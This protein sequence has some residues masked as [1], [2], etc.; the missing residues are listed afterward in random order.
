MKTLIYAHRGASGYAPENTNEAFALAMEQGAEGVELD[1][2]LT[3]DG[4]VIVTH[5]ERIDRVSDGTGL[6]SMLSV[7]D[8][9]K[10]LFNRTHPEYAEARAPLLEEVLE[11]MKPSGMG[12]NIELKNSRIPY[13][14]MESKC[15]DLAAKMGME[16]RI[17]YSSFNHHSMTFLKSLNPDAVCG[18]L[19]DCSLLKP[20]DYLKL[21]GVN[22]LHP[23]YS[24]LLLN[25][26]EY[27]RVQEQGGLIHVWT[28]NDDRAMRKVMN[29]GADILIT[30]FPDRAL[31]VRDEAPV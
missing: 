27:E 2:H 1:V 26:A 6:V 22:A 31:A 15:L 28:V 8:I 23:H 10:H 16:D 13:E 5:D 25:K 18:L 4:Q 30:N 24:D 21:S 11:L 20:A 29:A 14:G 19:Y 12:I 3:R 9:K 17:V 7:K